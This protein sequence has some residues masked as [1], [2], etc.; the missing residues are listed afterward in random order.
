MNDEMMEGKKGQKQGRTVLPDR[1][2]TP[3]ERNIREAKNQ[4]YEDNGEL[5]ACAESCTE[6]VVVLIQIIA[7]VV[8]SVFLTKG[9]V[10]VPGLG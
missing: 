7:Q 9:M 3:V 1:V 10:S 5:G 6:G 8:S 4:E 2:P